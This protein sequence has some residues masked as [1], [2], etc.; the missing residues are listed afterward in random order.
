MGACG[1]VS[2]AGAFLLDGVHDAFLR[3]VF[4]ASSKAKFKLAELG[5]DAGLY[6]A[7][8]SVL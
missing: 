6:G 5:G 8:V 1:G 4:H 7:A 2:A 3:H